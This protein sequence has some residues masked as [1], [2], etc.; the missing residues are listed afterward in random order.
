V[1]ES[2]VIGNEEQHA[3]SSS[4]SWTISLTMHICSTRR[5]REGNLLRLPR[6]FLRRASQDEDQNT[7][8]IGGVE[9]QL[10]YKSKEEHDDYSLLTC[11]SL[12][13]HS[14]WL[15]ALTIAI[16]NSFS[17]TNREHQTVE[18]SESTEIS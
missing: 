5:L 15:V 7:T 4:L 1:D 6:I 2:S 3:L 8:E 18:N 14:T 13:G 10:M 16:S 17:Q 9:I 12:G 11:R